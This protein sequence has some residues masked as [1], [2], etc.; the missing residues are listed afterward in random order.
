MNISIE[1]LF[2]DFVHPMNQPAV[3]KLSYCANMW[4]SMADS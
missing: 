4:Y 3:Y 2:L 1:F